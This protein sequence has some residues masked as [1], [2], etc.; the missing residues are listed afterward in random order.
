MMDWIESHSKR[1]DDDLCEER[2]YERALQD[3]HMLYFQQRVNVVVVAA[4]KHLQ[5]WIDVEHSVSF[6]AQGPKKMHT[7]F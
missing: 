2:D 5:V 1:Y 3:C 6:Q 7:K 4:S